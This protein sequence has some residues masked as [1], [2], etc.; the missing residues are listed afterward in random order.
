MRIRWGPSVLSNLYTVLEG[1]LESYFGWMP[2]QKLYEGTNCGPG[3]INK[4][5]PDVED[6]NESPDEDNEAKTETT[7]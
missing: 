1:L 2:Y 6:G 3:Y 5:K 4:N 7:V